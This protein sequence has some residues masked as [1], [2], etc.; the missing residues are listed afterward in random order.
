MVR[1]GFRYGRILKE[2]GLILVGGEACEGFGSGND[3]HVG[4]KDI[5]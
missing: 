5:S 2:C 1:L 3:G 4:R